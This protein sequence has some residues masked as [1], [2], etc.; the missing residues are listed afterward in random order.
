MKNR[1]QYKQAAITIGNQICRDAIWYNN[2]CNWVG[3]AVYITNGRKIY[4]RALPPDFYEGV[5]G[6][7]FFLLQVYRIHQHPV[8]LKTA[9]GA[10]QCLTNTDDTKLSNGFYHGRAGIIFVLKAAAEI[11]KDKILDREA[12]KKMKSLLGSL[13]SET[14]NDVIIGAAGIILFLLHHYQQYGKQA[15]LLKAAISL[16][17]G[18]IARADKNSRGYSWKTLEGFQQNLTGFAH[19]ASG[20][21]VALM[22]LYAVTKE[23]KFIFA[24][25]EAF[26][27]ED[28]FYNKQKHNWP[29]FRFADKAKPEAEQ[30]C[31][32]AWCHG[33]P[34][35][36]FARLRAYEITGHK[37]FLIAAEKA[38]SI[39]ATHLN[40]KSINDY[41][42]CHGLTGNALFL[43]KAAKIL[44]RKK[45][46]DI[47]LKLADNCIEQFIS[48]DIPFPN[49]YLT[50]RESPCLMQGNSGVGYFFLQ[51][52]KPGFFPFIL[53]LSED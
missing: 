40:Q 50:D 15:S 31:S 53:H 33:A 39:T 28:S 42:L 1:E 12:D 22:E 48:R 29:D 34:G 6:V 45:H 7:A 26:R 36:G 17:E 41:S 3:L 10:L 44:K 14:G 24:A 8:I 13:K 38:A 46:K 2:T 23:E 20:I 52:Y 25:K 4:S 18:L 27:Y 21:G 47:V 51:L 16:G 35:I 5:A 19:G 9:K 37:D 32:L 49:G 11:L 43:L 30:V